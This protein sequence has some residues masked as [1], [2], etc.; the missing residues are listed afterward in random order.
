MSNPAAPRDHL[1]TAAAI[2]L[3]A[4]VAADVAHHALGHAG[5]CLATG[6]EVRSLTSVFVDCT[7][8]GSVI[9]LAGPFA[10]LGVGLLA[11]G[12]LR[13]VRRPAARWFTAL[14]AAFDLLWFTG[15]LAFS[16]VSRRDDWAWAMR[17]A[18]WPDGL[19][20][21][22][23]GAAVAA[24]VLVVRA[25]GR[26]LA[27]FA[28]S[29]ARVTRLAVTAWLTAGGIAAAT[30]AFDPQGAAALLEHALPQSL[31]LAAGLLF[32]P[33]A[34]HRAASGERPTPALAASPGWIAAALLVAAASMIVLGPGVAL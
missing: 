32:M 27:A 16:A 8:H 3:V 18:A 13:L 33:S 30:A 20:W 25:V 2:A 22:V 15:Q 4:Y 19:R 31:L 11:F 12:G 34:A 9:D 28:T 29:H 6:G 10:S 17:R 21:G 23:A 7:R 1:P 24:Y 14:L 26:Q 5:A